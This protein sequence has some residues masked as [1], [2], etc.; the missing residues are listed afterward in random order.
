MRGP[1]S[2]PYAPPNARVGD[3]VPR[4]AAMPRPPEARVASVLLR[5]SIASSVAVVVLGRAFWVEATSESAGLILAALA[6]LALGALAYFVS[7][8]RNWARI[9]LL[10]LCVAAI[11][12]LS[13]SF[14]A[15]FHFS[16]AI[17]AAVLANALLQIGAVA[18]LFT[19]ASTAWFRS[20]RDG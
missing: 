4:A 3:V 10:A 17:A 14:Q 9:A 8:G 13:A 18:L 6:W 20:V 7:V 5:L 2:N 16:R 19:G 12:A 15:V 11:F 1:R